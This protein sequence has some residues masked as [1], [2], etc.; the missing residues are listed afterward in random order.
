MNTLKPALLSLLRRDRVLPLFTPDALEP[1]RTRLHTLQV[2]GIQAVELT[3]RVP[4]A[5]DH[6][7]A[8]RRDFPELLLGAGT[9]LDA[10]SAQAFLDL[11]A[12]FLV[13]P[14][15]VPEVAAARNPVPSKSALPA[16]ADRS[17]ATNAP[18]R[19]SKR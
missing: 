13:S 2:A 4:Q 1:A 14:C 6:F 15:L 3:A 9:I 18:E 19:A 17:G 8:L 16:G 11:G 10:A 7:A 12:D 5:A